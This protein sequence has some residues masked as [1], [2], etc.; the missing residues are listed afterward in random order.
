M[1]MELIKANRSA[2]KPI[3]VL[4]GESGSGKTLSALYL[5]RGFVGPDGKIAVIDSE[6]GR[7]SLYADVLP[8]GYDIL[9]LAEPFSPA[10]YIEAISVVEKSGA[11][12]GI[13]DSGSH[14]WDGLGGVLDMAIENE[15]RSGKPGL[16]NWRLP[17]IEHNKFLQK[18]LRSPIPWVICLRAKFKTKQAKNAQGKTEIVKDDYVTPI[19]ADDF[20]FEATAHGVISLMDHKFMLTK[21][22]HPELRKA[23]PNNEPFNY[24][25]GKMIAAWCNG[26]QQQAPANL[27]MPPDDSQVKAL[28]KKLWHMTVSKHGGKLDGLEMW[29]IAMDLMADTENLSDLTAKRLQ[30][31]IDQAPAKLA[32]VPA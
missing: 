22:S 13:I 9:Q 19:Q 26:G 5:A 10:K 29:L 15:T 11:A 7:G 16:H 31:I 27:S 2:T 3:I 18:L 21:C 17:K 8:G 32:E 12:I 25:H 6:S 4:Y 14:E 28:K 24:E 20:I 30:E 1:S 23:M